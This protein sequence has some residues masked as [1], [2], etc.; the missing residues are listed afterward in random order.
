MTKLMTM[1]NETRQE[2]VT[3]TRAEYC[4]ETWD[5]VEELAKQ[6]GRSWNKTMRMLIRL[7]LE[8]VGY[9]RDSQD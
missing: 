6:L 2:V 3:L 8:E 7:G 4:S 1:E 5:R 9:G